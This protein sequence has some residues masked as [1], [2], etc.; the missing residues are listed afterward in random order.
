MK[1]SYG[2]CEVLTSTVAGLVVTLLC[3]GAAVAVSTLKP[4]RSVVSKKAMK[5]RA[6]VVL[7]CVL[8]APFVPAVLLGEA[9]VLLYEA[10][11]R[12]HTPPH[13]LVGGTWVCG[14]YG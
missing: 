12:R 11:V 2:R 5:E 8:V 1:A 4:P 3:V 14:P 6:T 7:G 10:W 13:Q 9:V